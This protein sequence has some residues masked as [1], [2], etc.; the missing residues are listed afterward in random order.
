MEMMGFGD[1]G[2]GNTDLRAAQEIIYDAWEEV[3][4]AERIKMAQKALEISEDCVDAYTILAEDLAA[5]NLEKLSYYQ[6]GV[7]VGEQVLGKE[8]FKENQ[9]HFWGLIETRP[10]M[11]ALVGQ[12]NC[13]WVVGEKPK[14]LAIY[15]RM[16]MLNPG[17][18]QGVRYL[19]LDTL[20]EMKKYA[21]AEALIKEYPDVEDAVWLFTKALLKYKDGGHA[22]AANKLLKKAHQHNPFVKAYLTGKKRI[23]HDAPTYYSWG[24]EN[25]AVLYAKDHLNYWRR[26]PGAVDWFESITENEV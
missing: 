2:H 8:Y 10:Y 19:L 18:N 14:A 16:L 3:V 11:R 4:P 24:D 1:I 6:K 26:I 12:A 20:L 9:G 23:P 7:E 15:R 25:E 17:D 21:D 5:T 13:L 22:P